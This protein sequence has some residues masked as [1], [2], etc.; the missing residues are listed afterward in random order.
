MRESSEA[1]AFNGR[2]GGIALFLN[3]QI[4][5]KRGLKWLFESVL[6]TSSLAGPCA[7]ILLHPVSVK[8]ALGDSVWPCVELFAQG[9]AVKDKS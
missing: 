7:V 4:S 2:A 1:P 6:Y 9:A 5:G 8:G 3:G